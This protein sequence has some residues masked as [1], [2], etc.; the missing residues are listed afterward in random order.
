MDWTSWS[1]TWSTKSATT[2]SR[3]PLRWSSKHLRWK[4]DV[5]AFASRSKAEA[6]PK[7][8]TSACSPT[9]TVP[10][11]E[12]IWTDIEPGAQSNQARPVAK[13]LN[14][15]F[16]HGVTTQGRGVV[17]WDEW[18][19]SGSHQVTSWSRRRNGVV[20]EP[21]VSP[22]AF[23]FAGLP[24]DL[25]A[26]TATAPAP[27]RAQLPV[28]PPPWRIWPSPRSLC[29]GWG[30]EQKGLRTWECDCAGLQGGRRKSDDQRVGAWSGLGDRRQGWRETAWGGSRRVASVRRCPTCSRRHDSQHSSRGRVRQARSFSWGWRCLDSREEKEGTKISWTGGPT[31]QGTIGRGRRWGRRTLVPRDKVARES[32]CQG[33]SA[34]GDLIVAPPF[35]TSMAHAVGFADCMRS[36]A[37]RCPLTLGAP[38]RSRRWWRHS[39]WV[40]RG[41]CLPPCW[42]GV[43]RCAR[44][45]LEWAGC[46]ILTDWQL[47]TSTLGKKIQSGVPS[48]K[49]TEYSS[50][51]WWSTSRR[52][53]SD[54]TLEINRLSSVRI[55]EFLDIGLV[56]CG[57][58][59]W[60]EAETTRKD[61]NIVLIH[62]DKKFFIS[63]LFKAFQDAIPLILH[64][65]T[66]C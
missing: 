38:S 31:E 42:V 55:W 57:R 11:R 14:T 43:V 9:R 25:V 1:P 50:S 32:A 4:R 58:V 59:E 19:V 40:R 56:K 5:F 63:E 18:R 47:L 20:H 7:R 21:T 17:P 26:Q 41:A 8:P 39:S 62:Q 66:M 48:G 23:W 53:W 22:H 36:R 24:R 54:W 65:R 61:F 15:F 30:V 44:G 13:I 3:K 52:R 60:Q 46:A 64:F 27:N 29:K 2:T 34:A 12:R 45:A 6:K 37:S 33:Q 51:A 16:R 35:S 28:W 10:V 49:K